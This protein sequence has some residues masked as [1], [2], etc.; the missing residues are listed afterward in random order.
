MKDTMTSSWVPGAG[1]QLFPGAKPACLSCQVL[2]KALFQ[3]LRSTTDTALFY[4]SL[5]A[6]CQKL[7]FRQ[8]GV[9]SGLIKNEKDV[10]EYVVRRGHVNHVQLCALIFT[11]SYF[12]TPPCGLQFQDKDWSVNI[13]GPIPTGSSGQLKDEVNLN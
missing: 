9:C 2:A 3:F 6:I 8:P 12:P 11:S 10:M 4:K 1:K 7:L 13:P 5:I